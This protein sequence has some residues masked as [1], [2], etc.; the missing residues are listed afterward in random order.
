MGIQLPGELADLLNELGYNW[1]KADEEKLFQLGQRWLEFGGTLQGIV[2]DAQT[3]GDKVSADNRGDAIDAFMTKW[4]ADDSA[5]AVLKDG[6]TA[7]QVIGACLFVCAAIVLGLKINV[8]V[9]LT[10]LLIEII[11][12]IATAP[13]TFG[14]SLLEIPVFKKITDMIINFIINEAME[15]I[16]G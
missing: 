12:A 9:N 10:I 1:P 8:I 5:P 6:A 16:L 15:A 7:A 13:E 14:A 2:S 4:N 3:A 11:E